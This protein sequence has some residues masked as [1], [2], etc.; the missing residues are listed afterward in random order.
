MDGGTSLSLY[1]PDQR[2]RR[3]ASAWTRVQAVLAP[4][5]FVVFL[6][7]LA[8]VLRYLAT[9]QGE[10]AAD[11]SIAV[12][13]ATLYA[14]MVTGSF[15]EK[16][17]FGRWL[18]ARAFWWEDFA[19]LVVLALHTAWLAC[20]AGDWM[21]PRQRMVLALAAYAS[22]VVNATQY[23][24]KFRAARRSGPQEIPT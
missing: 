6:A 5:Q 23:L 18:F 24:I 9:S 1:T 16:Q 13:T 22:Y 8:L 14:I 12:K 4:F 10:Q 15:W 3:D 19:S 21:T 11:V 2:R 20:L 7:S 17:V